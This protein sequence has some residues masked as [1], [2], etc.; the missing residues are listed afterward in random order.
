MKDPQL[1][2]EESRRVLKR[3]GTLLLGFIPKE[4]KWAQFYTRKGKEGHPLYREARFY[5]LKVV[6]SMLKRAGFRQDK[7]LS[8]L[9]EEPQDKYPVRNSLI[10]E[11]FE[12]I[13]GFAC[14]KAT[15]N[16]I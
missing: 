11:G 12:P 9:L 4:S 6:E 5:P 15:I 8:T 16:I 13:A 7:M 3:D 2:L 14:I 1:A 10:R